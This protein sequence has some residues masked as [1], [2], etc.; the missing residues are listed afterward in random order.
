[1]ANR[2]EGAPTGPPAVTGPEPV[3]RAAAAI[4]SRSSVSPAVAVILGSGLGG[5]ADGLE[6]AVAV[7]FEEVPGFPRSTVP[8]HA[9]RFVLGSR[10]GIPVIVQAGRLHLY[11][12]Y[13][14]RVVAFPVRVLRA[15]GTRVLVATNA[16][17]GVHPS[18]RPGDLMLV[19]DHLSL[20]WRS[21]LRG[22]GP[23]LDASRFVDLGEPYSRR[24]LEAAH[25]AAR[26]EGIP[27]VGSGVYCGVLGPCYETPAEVEMIRKLGGDAVGMS[28]VPEVIAA[29]HAG[30]E[31]LGI[32]AIAN[33]AA[34]RAGAA[35]SH[36]DV[37]AAVAA[38]AERVRGLIDAVLPDL[39]RL[40]APRP[41]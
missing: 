13:P 14:A 38:S 18:L 40:G 3:E 35:L 15:L 16:A 19:T 6:D 27:R 28:T 23:S 30:M 5:Y 25:D 21:P 37:L 31:V 41:E 11:E 29:A 33:R 24:L 39:V 12:G 17:G 20:Q 32:A 10:R 2:S 36:R 1:M 4:R 22:R 9:G 26:R 7:P 34:S 8:G